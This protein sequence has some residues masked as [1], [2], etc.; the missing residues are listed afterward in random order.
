M[1]MESFW[2]RG[3]GWVVAQSVLM[4]LVC[5][6]GWVQRGDPPGWAMG[7]GVVLMGWGAVMGLAG[8]AV[9]GRNR[10][11]F[12]VPNPG[13]TLVRRG[14]FR[15]VRHPL[16][17]SLMG[18]AFGWTLWRW[19]WLAFVT[20]VMLTVLLRFKA[21]REERWLDARFPEHAD[22]AGRVARFVPFLW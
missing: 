18:L 19:S 22:Y 16:Y 17:S 11:I 6:A 10:T 5:L 8:V 3:G 7:L 20:S 1:R 12:P 14:I 13:S 2:S 4:P 9:L 21:V 15:W